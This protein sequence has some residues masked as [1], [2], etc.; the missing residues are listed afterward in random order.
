MAYVDHYLAL[1]RTLNYAGPAGPELRARDQRHMRQ[2]HSDELDPRA[3]KGVYRVIGEAVGHRI[4][5]ILSTPI[6]S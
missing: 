6:H 4:K 5:D 3:W 2:L 1:A